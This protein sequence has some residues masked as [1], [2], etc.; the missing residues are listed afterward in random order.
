MPPTQEMRNKNVFKIK[1][2]LIIL[3]NHPEK[4]HHDFVI[5]IKN[6]KQNKIQVGIDSIS[7]LKNNSI[8]LFFPY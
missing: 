2:D 6:K 1:I 3:T 5:K 4:V 7:L 8:S